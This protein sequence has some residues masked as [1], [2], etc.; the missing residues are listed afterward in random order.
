MLLKN[1]NIFPFLLILILSFSL[2]NAQTEDEILAG[3]MRVSP[4]ASVS[5]TI[6]FTNVTIDYGRPGVK[7]RKIWDGLV[8][9]D[10]L[11][12]AGANEATKFTFSNDVNIAGHNFKKGS[13]SF[14][15]IPGKNEWTLIFN[16]VADQWGPFT[17][18]E[19]KDEFRFKVKPAEN[20]HWQEWLAYCFTDIKVQPVGK[21]NSAVV[22]LE[23]AKLKVPFK[24]EVA[25]SK[26]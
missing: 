4:K 19:A 15:A 25:T 22:N 20:D 5:E 10:K 3:K 8:P 6:G 16:N 14:F 12:R 9:Y 21:I 23:W 7:G 18:N 13:Y 24:I 11:W 26:K 2:T 17:Y 1:K